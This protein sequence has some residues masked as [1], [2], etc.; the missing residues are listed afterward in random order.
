[1]KNIF[2]QLAALA[3]DLDKN[4][5]YTYANKIDSI[6]RSAIYTLPPDP[7]EGSESKLAPEQVNDIIDRWNAANG[8]E[9]VEVRV[10]ADDRITLKFPS[11]PDVELSGDDWDKLQVLMGIM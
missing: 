9:D 11:G 3:N 10:S 4:G 6:M 5:L 1:M 8:G 7:F 2:L